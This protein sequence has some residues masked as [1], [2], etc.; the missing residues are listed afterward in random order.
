[1][2]KKYKRGWLWLIDENDMDVFINTK[3]IES[4]HPHVANIVGTNPGDKD[5]SV[6]V[7]V[8]MRSGQEIVSKISFDYLQTELF[9][10]GDDN[11]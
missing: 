1:M 3:N 5:R 7:T 2:A 10:T 4:I 9:F 8:K 11:E 6:K